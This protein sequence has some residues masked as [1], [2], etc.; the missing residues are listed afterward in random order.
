MIIWFIGTPFALGSWYEVI[1]A[2][3]LIPIFLLRIKVEE[4]MLFKEMEGYSEYQNRVKYKLFP[5]LY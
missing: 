1:P 5:Y 2:I 3:L 4:S